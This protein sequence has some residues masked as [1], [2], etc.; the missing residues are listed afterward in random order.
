MRSWDVQIDAAVFPVRVLTTLLMLFAGGSLLIAAIGQYA[1]VSFDTRRRARE[2]GLRMAL[3]SS[4][5]QVIQTVLREG[6]G[7]TAAGLAIGFALSLAVGRAM[8]GVLY[9]I[10]PIDPTTYA[11]VFLLL[12]AASLLACYLPARRASRINPMNALRTE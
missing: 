5:S 11:G 12:S 6:F 7:L 2:V 9:G 1:L 10:T 3:G 4:A 8:S